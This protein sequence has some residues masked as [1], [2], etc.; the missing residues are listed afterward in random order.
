MVLLGFETWAQCLTI[1]PIEILMSFFLQL[2]QIAGVKKYTT[3]R[4][5]FSFNINKE[6]MREVRK[7]NKQT[8][9]KLYC[10][11]QLAQ[12]RNQKHLGL[13]HG[14]L[15]NGTKCI[16]GLSRQAGYATGGNHRGIPITQDAFQRF[17]AYLMI[18]Q[19]FTSVTK[20]LN[21]QVLSS[22]AKTLTYFLKEMK[23]Q[24]QIV[25]SVSEARLNMAQNWLHSCSSIRIC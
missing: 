13:V 3:I 17:Q 10:I 2:L 11:L 9:V 12:L 18:I 16:A 25:S 4:T 24:H 22:S 23:G 21:V 14:I 5:L 8:S 15:A 20:E 7:T 1:L 6:R 19:K